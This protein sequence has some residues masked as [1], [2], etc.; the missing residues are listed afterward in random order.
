MCT[1]QDAKWD[2]HTPSAQETEELS[3]TIHPQ[4]DSSRHK[5]LD[6][7]PKETATC[8]NMHKI[9]DEPSSCHPRC[10]CAEGYVE[11]SDGNCI[12]AKKCPCHHGGRSYNDNEI[13]KQRCNTWFVLKGLLMNII[14]NNNVSA[15][16]RGGP[17]CALEN[18]VQECAQP[19]ERVTT[20]HLMRRCL[21]SLVTVNIF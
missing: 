9:M 3:A 4:C 8:Q 15:S 16:V 6:K 19:G 20:E 13:I 17:G 21:I 5:I 1:C 10:V 7:C 12:L 2:C 11:D 14:Q 18:N